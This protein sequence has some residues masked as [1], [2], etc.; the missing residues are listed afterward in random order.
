[1]RILGYTH[2]GQIAFSLSKEISKDKNG[3]EQH[4]IKINV[5]DT[6]YGIPKDALPRIF[7]RY[8]QVEGKH[9]AAGT[10]IGL[11]LVA[12]LVKLHLGTINVTSDEGKGS[13]F[14]VTL[15]ADET[16][17]EANHKP[18]GLSI[19]PKDETENDVSMKKMMLV[20]EDNNDVRKYI[21]DS[22]KSQ[23]TILEAANG[24]EGAE[25]AFI[26]IPDII[27]SDIMM[28]EMNGIELCNMLKSD[29]RTSH[30]PVIML[31]AKDTM[32][33]R[34]EGYES[35]ADSYIAKP[36]SAKLLKTRVD[37]LLSSRKVWANYILQHQPMESPTREN[38]LPLRE[39]QFIENL[40]EL[41]MQNI[42]A[43]NLDISFLTDKL[44][45]SHSTCYRKIKGL[46]GLS[47]NEYVR[48]LRLT[49]A[50]E[51]L[52]QN[53][54]SITEVAYAC[55]FSSLSYFRTCFKEVYD[56]SPKE[57]VQRNSLYNIK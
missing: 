17:K 11:A 38:V 44:N 29:M 56:V 39:R 23:Y 9:Q 33:D 30:I 26:K 31:T 5:S 15:N 41:I 21:S 50:A 49:K 47:P 45:M 55:G 46:T 51:L 37:N 14:T 18:E 54:M 3:T 16:Y 25:L 24:R 12:A 52:K 1:M 13:S 40:N 6:G 8:Y 2:D 10:G 34:E 43:A 35:G 28:P 53:E 42:D 48:R 27:I 7:D 19:A 57:Y 4:H 20:V 36:F 32:E 22:F